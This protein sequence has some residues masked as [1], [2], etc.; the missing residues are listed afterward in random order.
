MTH[1]ALSAPVAIGPAE[2]DG[3]HAPA[4]CLRASWRVVVPAGG[5]RVV[6]WRVWPTERPSR[7]KGRPGSGGWPK[8]AA[9]RRPLSRAAARSRGP[10]GCR[11]PGL[12]RASST[13]IDTDNQIF[14][15]AIRRSLIICACS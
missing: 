12:D 1:I 13:D 6:E 5:R 3:D 14:S 15:G 10:G 7:E 2:G 11:V 9:T 8:P 4:R